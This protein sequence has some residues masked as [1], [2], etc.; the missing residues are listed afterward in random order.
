VCSAGQCACAS[1]TPNGTACTLP[2]QTNGTCSKGVCV[3]PALYPGCTVAADCVPGGCQGGYCLGTVDVAGQV[4]CVGIL[5]WSVTCSTSQGCT[6]SP[7]TRV[8][9]FAECGDGNGGTGLITCDGP[10]DCPTGSDCCYYPN[11]GG[12]AP[13]AHCNARTSSGVIGS[14][15]PS[16]GP[17]NMLPN[18]CDPVNPTM[19]CPANTSCQ[20]SPGNP[21]VSW[22]CG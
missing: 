7:Q 9:P 16:L 1:S 8:A 4:T 2:G 5:G 12:G 19:Y 13:Q 18:L 11:G 17:G 10:N 21:L 6:A 15:C 22:Y 3:L 14:G 20:T